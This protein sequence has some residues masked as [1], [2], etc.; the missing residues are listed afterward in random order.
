MFFA[1]R[2]SKISSDLCYTK[3]FQI[4]KKQEK[5]NKINFELDEPELEYYNLSFI[6]GN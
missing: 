5:K 2:S 1:S 3:D 6:L 4:K